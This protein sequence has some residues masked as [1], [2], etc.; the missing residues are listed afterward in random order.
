M[1]TAYQDSVLLRQGI[2]AQLI[3]Y[4]PLFKCMTNNGYT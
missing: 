4:Q 1:K 3:H 2:F